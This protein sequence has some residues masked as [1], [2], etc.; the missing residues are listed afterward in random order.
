MSAFFEIENGRLMSCQTSEVEIVIPENVRIIGEGVFKG[1]RK[2]VK[3]T[4][5]N[6]LEIIENGAFKGCMSLSEI[7]FPAALTEI[8]DYAF[9]RCHSL[10]SV[11]LPDSVEKLGK[12]A[13]LYCDGMES[14]SI[15][16]VRRLER[17][18]FAN[19]TGLREIRLNAF[20]ETG[21]L[22]DDIF[23][24]CVNIKKIELTNGQRFEFENLA[25]IIGS[26]A[27]SIAQAVAR[28]VYQSMKLE[29]GIL[30]KLA[31]NL[32]SFSIPEGI[33]CIEKSCFYNKKGIT[34]IVLPESLCEIKANAFGNCINLEEVVFQNSRIKIDDKAFKGCNNLERV[35][36][37]GGVYYPKKCL[38]GGDLPDFVRLIGAQV[39]SDFYISGS[40][41]MKYRGNE[42][43]V[44]VPDAI[45]VIGEGCFENNAT[46]GRVVLPNS[47]REICENAFRGCVS[48]QTI[49][50]SEELEVIEKGA[51]ENCK[52]L[53]KI[54]LPPKVKR[55]GESAFKRCFKLGSFTVNGALEEIGDMAFYGCAVLKNLE[56]PPKTAIN[57]KLVF[58]NSGI[59]DVHETAEASDCGKLENGISPY[60]FCRNGEIVSLR[61]C[62]H[63]SKCSDYSKMGSERLCGQVLITEPDYIGKYAFSSCSNLREVVIDNPGCV[64]GERAFEKCPNLKSVKLN[65]KSIGK[66]AFSFCGSLETIEISGAEGIG[67]QA[68]WG[69]GKLCG[70][71]LADSVAEIGDR[72][73]EECVSIKAFDFRNIKTIGERAF[74]RCEGFEEIVL[75]GLCVRRCAFEDCCFVRKISL[76]PE[77]ELKSGAFF[78]CTNLREI[79]LDGVS[80]FPESFSQSV[81]GFGNTLPERVQEVIA[82]VFSC[83]DIGEDFALKKYTGNA[84]CVKIPNDITALG[85]EAFRNRIRT[86]DIE[87]PESVSNI[88]KLTFAGSGWLEKMRA[89]NK[90]TVVNNMIIDA[91]NCGKSA[92][93]PAEIKRVCSWSFAGNTELREVRFLG[94][95]TI[96][97]EYAFRNCVGLRRI[98]DESGKFYEMTG[99]SSKDDLGL[100]EFV[101]KIFAECV[102]CFKVDDNG[103]LIESTGNIKNLAFVSG[104]KAIGARVYKDCNLLCDIALCTE[105]EVI[106][107]SAFENGKWLKTVKN[108]VGVRRIE[109]LAF[110]GCQNLE[111][112]ELSDKLEYIGKRAF[113]HCCN[114]RGI[115]IPE[116]VREIR[117]R[118]FFRCKSLKRIVLPSTLEIIEKEAFAFCSE[119][120]DVVFPDGLKTVGERAFVHCPNLT[121]Y[122]IPQNAGIDVGAFDGGGF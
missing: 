19:C 111:E 29:N 36:F 88:G 94:G 60:E 93:I 16:G 108:A 83:F 59:A 64:I 73:F 51:F 5:P 112:I 66:G 110:C 15:G 69:C 7:N 47:V 38:S 76:A 39:L 74:S 2:I 45:T 18:T 13:F 97:D 107:E 122:R 92:E 44:C 43:R 46:L 121:Q 65:V 89:E 40:I 52:R 98:I 114:L 20:L 34:R 62:P 61:T 30:Y 11:I 68:F 90:L 10:K 102:N 21:N 84:V 67:E 115:V 113:E 80:Y 96:V 118:T 9:H 117:E 35:V 56:L 106:G 24:G 104:I 53:I 77:T 75:P 91:F 23:T 17:Q 101:R 8:C 31:V 120:E 26:D 119:L 42:E 82:S 116:G 72:C 41:L 85:D 87:I 86:V 12:C 33:T 99:I 57:G 22:G 109:A 78:G 6:S 1:M 32:K 103:T 70:I 55:L 71:K 3:V 28:S 48:M 105:T 58:F 63:S 50:L 37:D 54:A 49:E 81:R 25:A 95:R 14:V 79:A 27:N 100:P 4:L